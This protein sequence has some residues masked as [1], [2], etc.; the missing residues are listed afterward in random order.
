MSVSTPH[1]VKR[2]QTTEHKAGNFDLAQGLSLTQWEAQTLFARN[3]CHPAQTDGTKGLGEPFLR[4]LGHGFIGSG[5][6]ERPPSL[7]NK[8]LRFQ[9]WPW[10]RILLGVTGHLPFQT[11]YLS[12]IQSTLGA[13]GF[14][15]QYNAKQ[16]QNRPH[17]PS[18][19][20][21]ITL[22]TVI[23]NINKIYS[24]LTFPP[25]RAEISGYCC[26]GKG[27]G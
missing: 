24:E 19:N 12:T 13:K 18:L 2:S 8:S 22:T 27:K 5:S 11:T 15:F 7:I 25:E 9:S 14:V 21:L 16:L 10:V 1:R 20:H 26:D 3:A 4:F 17:A 23:T 6:E